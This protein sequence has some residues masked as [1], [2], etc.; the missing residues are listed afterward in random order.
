M[1]SLKGTNSVVNGIQAGFVD[2]DLTFIPNRW[3]NAN[4]ANEYT[5]TGTWFQRVS[6]TN[7]RAVTLPAPSIPV[8]PTLSAGTVTSTSIALNWVDNSNNELRFVLYRSAT[9]NN[10][11][12]PIKTF[13]ASNAA[14]GSYVD[15]EVFPNVRYYYRL[16][17]ENAGGKSSSAVINV[18]TGNNAPDI[19]EQSDV[20]MRYDAVMLLDVIASDPDQEQLVLSA[21]GLPSF[22]TLADYGDG[23]GLLRIEPQ[24]ADQGHY[25]IRINVADQHSGTDFTEF[26]LDINDNY[27]PTLSG[28][29][30]VVVA[31]G[32]SA[33]LNLTATD[34]NGTSTLTWEVLGLPEFAT[35]VSQPNG[36]ATFSF[37]PYYT[38]GG[39]YPIDVVLK[40]GQG[41]ELNRSFSIQVNEVNPN[42]EVL[43]NFSAGSN[44]PAP[45]NNV[46]TLNTAN[47]VKKDGANSGM[48]LAFQ[49]TSWKAFTDGATTGNNSGIYPDIVLKEYYYFGIFG[50]PNTVSFNVTG[51]NPSRTYDF[52]FMGSSIWPNV[53]N[54]GTTNYAIGGQTVSLAV[55]GNTSQLATISS[56]TPNASGVVTV[57]MTKG[58]STSAGYLNA[59]EIKS[60]VDAN[61]APAPARKF[62]AELSATGTGKLTWIDAPF[63]ET[64][65]Q[66]Y[67]SSTVD[68]EY[69]LLTSL[70]ANSSAYEDASVSQQNEYYYKVRSVNANGFGEAGPVGIFVPDVAPRITVT[71]RTDLGIGVVNNISVSLSDP[72]LNQVSLTVNN[73]PSFG[74]VSR[75]GNTW[76]LAFTPQL[77]DKGSYTLNLVGSDNAGNV[78]NQDLT[79]TVTEAM[80]FE[81]RMNFGLTPSANSTWNNTAKATPVAGDTFNNLRNTEGATTSVGLQLQTNFGGYFAQG[82]TTGNNSGIVPDD[83][84]REYYWFGYFSAPS[85]VSMKLTGLSQ[86]N[87]YTFKFVGSSVFADNGVVNN[88]STVYTIAGKSASVNVQANTTEAAVIESVRANQNGEVTITLTKATGTP[89]GYINAMMIEA[90]P[91]DLT[92]LNPTDLAAYGQDNTVVLE[93]KDNAFDEVGYQI[94]RADAEEGPWGLVGTVGANQTTYTD[95]SPEK[96]RYYKVRG[97]FPGRSSNDTN[98]ASAGPVA[99]KIYI[100]VNGVAQFDAPVPWNNLTKVPVD[101]DVFTGIRNGAGNPTGMALNFLK[102][103]EG[104]NDW[105][106]TTGNNSGI[107]P[108]NVLKSFYWKNALVEPAKVRL[109]NVDLAFGY[110]LSFFGSIVSQYTVSTNFSVGNKTVTNAQ[111]NNL[112]T[113]SVIRG[114]TADEDG[115]IL[116]TINEGPGSPWAIWNAL[117]IEAYPSGSAKRETANARGV[118]EKTFPNSYQV[119]YGEADP[120]VSVYPNPSAGD[121]NVR[122][123]DISR[124]SVGMSIVDFYGREV[125]SDVYSSDVLDDDRKIELQKL[126]LAPGVY[127]IQVHFSDGRTL[128][129]RFIVV[130]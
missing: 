96:L 113:P 45:W 7:A 88:G 105:G 121:I 91:L 50:A 78:V 42:V 20:I 71:G 27:Q 107:Y 60:V 47:L 17:V 112:N 110:N 87:K 73:L 37:A 11:F 40:D 80:A 30:D 114:V 90:Y 58:A 120:K 46:K 125:Y 4:N 15:E 64:G 21:S 111:N 65:Y 19:T 123:E 34:Q 6:G 109:E 103:M 79:L 99:F 127:I 53:A 69:T 59:L 33:T 24:A 118:G 32:A 44:A 82:A 124:G 57:T 66:I 94:Y 77:S 10:N 13:E 39:S 22:V 75:S 106:P 86:Y 119:R 72:P 14:N 101:F 51:L 23:T 68:G 108:D 28:I 48:G 2:G 102:N 104:H 89:I 126:N 38:D 100:N 74:T 115:G 84:L 81:L 25:V 97:V 29:A 26:N 36:T 128:R 3:N 49:T 61:S 52:S 70:P 43:V 56:V 55:Q 117:V 83:V 16:E 95:A 35:F 62:K 5:V 129:E 31:E 76:N 130:N 63:N 41:G 98:I 9:T 67:R 93:W 122:L 18:L 85:Q 116:F 1:T 92:E 8:A 12:V 54:N